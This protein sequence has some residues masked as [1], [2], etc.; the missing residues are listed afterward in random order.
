MK[1]AIA[2]CKKKKKGSSADILIQKYFLAKKCCHWASCESPSFC[3]WRVLSSCWWLLTDQV[4]AAEGWGGRGNLF[5][6]D[7]DT[8]CT[9]WLF[10]Q[11]I[12]LQHAMLRDSISPT[13]NFSKLESILSNSAPASSTKFMW[14][15]KSCCRF[16]HLRSPCT[17]STVRLKK[18]LFSSQEA[19]LPL[20]QLYHDPA[21]IQSRPQAPLLILV[22]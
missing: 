15:S 9:H 8:C 22:L 13:A 21:A 1:Y 6:Q 17:R 3:W 2:L 7:D 11:T 14:Y 10:P 20:L 4:V 16:N 19:T 18:A 12:S 5:Q